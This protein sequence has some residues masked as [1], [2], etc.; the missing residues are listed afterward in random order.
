MS[1]SPDQAA[2]DILLPRKR[3][4]GLVLAA[5]LLVL[6]FALPLAARISPAFEDWQ[7]T[8]SF[9]VTEILNPGPVARGHAVFGARCSAC[10]EKAFRAVGDAACNECHARTGTHLEKDAEH[11]D[12]LARLRCI[13]CHAGHEPRAESLQPDSAPCLECHQRL[14]GDIAKVG[15]FSTTHPE[16]RLTIPAGKVIQRARQDAP[17]LP[18]ERNGLKFS[19]QV[20]L[21]KEGV[22]SPEGR[23]LMVCQDCH[24]LNGDGFNFAPM[25]MAQSCQQSRC[26]KLRFEEPVSGLILH[27]PEKAVM[28]HVRAH[29]A[30]WLADEP[31]E[32]RRACSKEDQGNSVR[33]A[34]D[35][36]E[37]LAAAYAD[38]SLFQQAG[39]EPEC[40]LC[41]EASQTGRAD[42]PWRVAKP[43]TRHDWQPNARFPH[44]RHDT[45]KCV[46]CHDKENSEK[47]ADIA[48]PDIAKCRECHAGRKAATAKL[49]SH[50]ASCHPFHRV[51]RTPEAPD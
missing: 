50:C 2:P 33:R 37:R 20:H 41:H 7:A 6:L 48:F 11:S 3:K 47:S 36:A 26:H 5:L 32:F 9:P 4:I 31:T 45:L 24:K 27:G 13:D 12:K 17:D 16:F 28:Q 22:S 43:R 14:G 30:N 15:D 25:D 51:A 23:T 34:L 29:F 21:D 38:S 1:P 35:C 10:H 49:Q 19:H 39:E 8:L 46:E 18:A 40:T 42:L 44:D